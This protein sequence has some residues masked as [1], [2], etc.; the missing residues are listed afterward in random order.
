MKEVLKFSASWCGPCQALSMTLKGLEDNVI[1]IKEI[2]ID[3]NLDTAA[4]YN[5]RSVPTMVM[6][7]NGSE[8]KRVSGA[9]PVAK[10]KEFLNG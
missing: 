10:V 3:D 1:P 4:Q 5:I 9:L 8:I 2:D 6:L 7:E